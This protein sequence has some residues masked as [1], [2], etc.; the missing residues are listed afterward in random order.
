L[1][2]IALIAMSSFFPVTANAQTVAGGVPTKVQRLC[3]KLVHVDHVPVKGIPNAFQDKMTELPHVGLQV[4]R[5]D[6]ERDYSD[7]S[8]LMA[9]VTTGRFGTFDFSKRKLEAGPYWVVAVRDARVY[10]LLVKYEPAKDPMQPCSAQLFELDEAG[11]FEIGVTV[12]L[13]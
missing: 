5:A 7:Q 6:G 10:R 1:I 13:D 12:T 3:G 8:H 9:E 2:A 4:Y 11:N